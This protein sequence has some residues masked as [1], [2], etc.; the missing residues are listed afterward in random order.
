MALRTRPVVVIGAGMGGL[1]AAA[2]LAARGRDVLVLERAARPGG[3]IREVEAGGAMVGAG[4]ALLTMRDVFEGIFAEA[5][6]SLSASLTLRPETML[7]RHAWVDGA[8]LDLPVE[9]DAAEA[10]VGAFGGAA[11][12][13]GYRAFRERARRIHDALEGP[14]L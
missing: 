8:R 11:A 7:G 9:A 6:G 13:R 12:A 3:K 2:L 10:A 1:V 14:Y 5:G 4:P